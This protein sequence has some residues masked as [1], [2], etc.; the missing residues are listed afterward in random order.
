V[1]GTGVEWHYIAPGKPQQNGFVGSFNGRLRD[2]CLNE[3]LFPSLAAAR[4]IIEA[5]RTD[6]TPC[7]RTAAL[8]G[9][10]PP[11][12]PTAHA[13]GIRKPKLTY[14]RPENGEHVKLTDVGVI[15]LPN[16]DRRLDQAYFD[17]R[18]SNLVKFGLRIV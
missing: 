7:V 17:N 12:L 1:P 11:S 10:H 15:F 18:R 8:A 6:T 3:H 5:W 16:D 14:Q 2:E 13:T 4:R 9:S